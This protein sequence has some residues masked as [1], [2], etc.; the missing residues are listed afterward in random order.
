MSTLVSLTSKYWPAI[1]A[2]AFVLYT[3]LWNQSDLPAAIAAFLATFGVNLKA[4]APSPDA[5]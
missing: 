5:K 3:A 1:G 4:V 2:A